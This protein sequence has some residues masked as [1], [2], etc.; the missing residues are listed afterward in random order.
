ML[1]IK[2]LSITNHN[3]QILIIDKLNLSLDKGDKLALIGEEGSG[4]SSFIK[5][6]FYSALDYASVEFDFLSTGICTYVAQ[7]IVYSG[8]VLSYLQIEDYVLFYNLMD[9]FGLEDSIRMREDFNTLSGGEK[10]KLALIKSFM[11]PVDLMILDEPTNNLDL[12]SIYFLETLCQRYE[13]TL[14]F[15]SHDTR[16][17]ENLANKIYHF[18]NINRRREN[19]QT[20][21]NC[22]YNEFLVARSSRIDQQRRT[23]EAGRKEIAIASQKYERVHDN[24]HHALNTISRQAPQVAKNLKDKMRQV[25]SVEKKI[26]KKKDSLRKPDSYETAARF[27]LEVEPVHTKKEVVNLEL[28]YLKIGDIIL[29]D[30]IKLKLNGP[31]KIA[32][33]GS[34]GVGKTTL[35]KKIMDNT[36]LQ[37]AYM[38][39][40]YE[41]VIDVKLN[42]I[43]LLCD[44]KIKE[45]QTK[46]MTYL[47]S[48]NFSYE[49]MHLAF[50]ELSGG[51]KAKV[52]F[53]VMSLNKTELL[54][55]D[56]PTRNIS[57]LSM[58]TLIQEIKK[59][60]GAI[61]LVTH[62]RTLL[63]SGLDCIYELDSS[64]L[65]PIDINTYMDRYHYKDT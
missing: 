48:L 46:A 57:S 47:G 2:N 26:Q 58:N 3:T 4:K 14:I 54:I 61:I 49:E 6:I 11:N 43:E 38:P 9:G 63:E 28:P 44:I 8:S 17:V 56:E 5:A 21:Y 40:N 16:F 34:N 29:T 53:A 25:K 65:V 62:D 60:R 23:Y 59:F 24:V 33:I 36:S 10:T 27:T 1:H 13:G 41:D 64:G 31:K 42:A 32:I 50:E 51:Q 30:K 35:I 18:E 12:K 37:Y 20:F 15:S 22:S 39:Q 55:L 19:K 52:F 7:E 45:E